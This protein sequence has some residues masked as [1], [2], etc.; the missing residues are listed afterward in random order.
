M[1]TPYR[2]TERRGIGGIERL[3]SMS[4]LPHQK[5]R[6]QRTRRQKQRETETREKERDRETD[7]E[8][9]RGLKEMGRDRD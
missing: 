9:K 5:R 7:R 2:G 4:G 6:R 8:R 1:L 3:P